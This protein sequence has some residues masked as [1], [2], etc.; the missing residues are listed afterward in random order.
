MTQIQAVHSA[1]Y[2]YMPDDNN[3]VWGRQLDM[4]TP[5]FFPTET[6]LLDDEMH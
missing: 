3:H 5:H 6:V 2:W 4:I 1:V